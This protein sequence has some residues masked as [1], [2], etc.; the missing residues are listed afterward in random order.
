MVCQLKKIVLYAWGFNKICTLDS[1]LLET[2]SYCTHNTC[3]CIY[4]YI[5]IYTTSEKP[6]NDQYIYIYICKKLPSMGVK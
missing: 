3:T 2:N 1:L 6:V 5:Y 4:I